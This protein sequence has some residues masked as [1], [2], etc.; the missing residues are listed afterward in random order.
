MRSI[1]DSGRAS[2]SHLFHRHGFER[3][4]RVTETHFATS[5]IQESPTES[6]DTHIK[7]GYTKWE[8]RV[9]EMNRAYRAAEERKSLA[10]PL[11]S[12]L[13]SEARTRRKYIRRCIGHDGSAS[14]PELDS[15]WKRYEAAAKL[16]Q[17]YDRHGLFESR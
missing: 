6:I 5:E 8:L 16:C 13:L 10:L 14:D 17:E 1:K 15:A 4:S 11:H 2:L 9:Q 7:I 3:R 12:Q